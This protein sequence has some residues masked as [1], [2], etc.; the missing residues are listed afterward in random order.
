MAT[1]QPEWQPTEQ[2]IDLYRAA[3]SDRMKVLAITEDTF[4]PIDQ[5]EEIWPLWMWKWAIEQRDRFVTE[6]HAH[7]FAWWRMVS[8]N[9][10]ELSVDDPVFKVFLDRL[11]LRWR[12]LYLQ[13][14]AATAGTPQP[15]RRRMRLC[16]LSRAERQA[17]LIAVD[18]SFHS[19]A[20]ESVNPTNRLNQTPFEPLR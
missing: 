11:F 17:I 4:L 5:Y 10:S 18:R 20:S 6:F 13:L 16:D 14:V 19:P 8:P 3:V 9:T 12:W 1:S 2:D 7:I 15:L